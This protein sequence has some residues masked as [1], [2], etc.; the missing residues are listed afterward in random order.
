MSILDTIAEAEAR[1]TQIRN[2]ARVESREMLRTMEQNALS[3]QKHAL[4]ACRSDQEKLAEEAR[5]KARLS[6]DD[7]LRKQDDQDQKFA[8]DARKRLADTV[9]FV[10]ERI[11]DQ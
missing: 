9:S 6:M 4:D 11:V 2:D 1:A 8:E 3:K 5:V 10:L 7:S